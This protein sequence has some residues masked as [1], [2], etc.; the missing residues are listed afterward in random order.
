MCPLTGY[1]TVS[2]RLDYE[3]RTHYT[4]NIG[5]EDQGTPRMAAY[6]TLV[7]KVADV[8]DN[9]PVFDRPIYLVSLSE[10]SRPHTAILRVLATDADTGND[11]CQV[12]QHCF[13]TF[14]FR[15]I[16]CTGID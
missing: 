14:C 8:N 6:Q 1:L 16:K 15:R 13:Y 4:L 7:I 12:S 2:E 11:T 10:N 3:T 9:A 5:A